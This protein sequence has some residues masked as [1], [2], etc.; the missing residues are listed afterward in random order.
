MAKRY[1][2]TVA[3]LL[4]QFNL[5]M[6]F[7]QYLHQLLQIATALDLAP[8][9]RSHCSGTES[10]SR[11]PFSMTSSIASTNWR[12]RDHACCISGSLRRFPVGRGGAFLGF[13]GI[14][15]G[16]KG[17][18]ASALLADYIYHP[19]PPFAPGKWWK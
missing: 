1:S 7:H 13:L 8:N 17:C 2:I 11:I 9:S 12:V 19:T 18:W 10:G 4:L 15:F 3:A 5:T 16:G 14:K 6:K